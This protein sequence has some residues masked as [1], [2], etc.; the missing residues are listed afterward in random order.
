MGAAPAVSDGKDGIG[1]PNKNNKAVVGVQDGRGL[2]LHT[3][4]EKIWYVGAH[5]SFSIIPCLPP[6]PL[7]HC[8][9]SPPVPVQMEDPMVA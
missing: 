6:V 8:W 9:S 5:I 7:V 2:L 4:A 1:N 3:S